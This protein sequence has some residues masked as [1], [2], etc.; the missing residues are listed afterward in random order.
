MSKPTRKIVREDARDAMQ[1]YYIEELDRIQ[2]KHEQERHDLKEQAQDLA[3]PKDNQ[4]KA[5]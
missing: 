3:Y 1:G 5:K 4:E 2:R